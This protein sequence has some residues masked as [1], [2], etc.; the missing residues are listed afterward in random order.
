MKYGDKP[1]LQETMRKLQL[2][3][4]ITIADNFQIVLTSDILNIS[5]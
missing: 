5:E 1:L 2:L 3:S 4:G